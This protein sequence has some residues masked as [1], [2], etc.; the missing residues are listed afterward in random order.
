M[1]A[2]AKVA[3]SSRSG[4][5]SP[6][7]LS[8][9]ALSWGE[10]LDIIDALALAL[11]GA[12]AHLT[13]K[14]ALY[15]FDVLRALADLRRQVP[16]LSDLGFH[17]ALTE[18]VS[19]LRD[20]HTQYQGPWR[21]PGAVVSL[22]FLVE[23]FGPAAAPEYV[24]SK[25]DRVFVRDRRFTPGVVIEHWNGIPFDRAVERHAERETG[26]R[27]DARR[28]RALE[29]LT[30]RSLA[31][32]PPPDEEWV[33]VGYRDL[34][35]RRRQVRLEWDEL[36]PER[37][38][39][40]GPGAR[41][42]GRGRMRRAIDPAA[43]AVRRAKKLRFNRTLWQ[44]ERAPAARR[45]TKA[46]ALARFADFLTARTVATRHGRFGYLRIWSFDLDDD[47][48]FLEA[49]IALLRRLPD[50]GLI[51]DLRG[52]PGG[53]IWAAERMLQ[54]FTPRPVAPTKFALRATPLTLA[55]ARA[56]QNQSELGPWAES[57]ERAQQTGEAYSMHLPITP[58]EQCNDLGQHYGG[59]IVVV[60]DANTYSSGDLFAAGIADN[61]IGTIVT[62]GDATGAGGANVW[63]AEDLAAALRAAG[64]PL[65]D[66][67]AGAS[68]RMA[69]RRAVRSNDAEGTLIEDA[70]IGGQPYD[71][72][73]D[74]IFE[75]NRDL[76]E[77]CA[78]ILAA[79]PGTGLSV[80]RRG[81]VATVETRGLDRLDVYVD[82]RPFTSVTLRRDGRRSVRL[83]ARAGGVEVV[84]FGG[85]VVRQRRRVGNPSNA[86]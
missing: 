19:R 30:F 2:R 66:L 12:Y 80:R 37:A 53:L 39:A 11:E 29:S 16:A 17:R 25:V 69:L 10:R 13:L 28:A 43:E 86:A 18:L 7:A 51:I 65:P 74:D 20:A 49:A 56:A 14:R 48:A 79:E 35:G 45:R 33:V 15:G 34:D 42:G 9:G 1:S 58:P 64:Q 68:F 40:A 82:G 4:A 44:A 73:R 70:G 54:L 32:A 27:P 24:V 41:A 52:N 5:L 76:I 3:A 81:A 21:K 8:P 59:P 22:P 71:M 38:P 57:L 72:T 47:A 61:R 78:G 60:V 6:G 36:A 83:P 84:G 46:G 85:G 23:A 50:R 62:V 63:E 55:M 77:H 31:D 75:G 67:P 26:G